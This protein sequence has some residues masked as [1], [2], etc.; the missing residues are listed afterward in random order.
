MSAPRVD[1]VEVGPGI[2]L[3]CRH[4]GDG[5]AAGGPPVLLLHGNRDNHTHFDQLQA[6]LAGGHRTTALDFRGHGLSSTLDVPAGFDLFAEDVLAVLDHHGWERVVLVGH[7]F[8]SGVSM[9]VSQR[10]PERVAALVLMGSAVVFT[11]PFKRPDSPPT[12]ETFAEFVRVANERARPVFFHERHPEI[13][14]QVCAVWS[15][16]SWD[17]HRNLVASGHPDMRPVVKELKVPTL[18]IAGEHDRCTPP[19]QARWI[20]ENHRSA[21]LRIVPDTAHFM[22]M[23]E[24]AV[25]AREIADFVGRVEAG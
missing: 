13:V 5:S 17:V 19:D 14:G 3:F 2:S 1:Y 11:L 7:S 24:P 4:E 22:Y 6:H 23:E 25:V 9:T 21:E 8:G 20:H 18:V 12:R 10:W 15:T 16:I